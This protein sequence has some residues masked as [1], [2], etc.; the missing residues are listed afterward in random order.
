MHPHDH[1]PP[2]KVILLGNS[3]V[4]KTSLYNRWINNVFDPAPPPTIGASNFSK[5]VDLD[6]KTIRISLWDTAGQDQFRS[7]TPLYI[8]GAK[9]A[10][11]VAE[12]NVE[13]FASLEEWLRMVRDTLTEPIGIVLAVNKSE[14]RE[15]WG[16][17]ELAPL[18][19]KQRDVFVGVFAVSAKMGTNV[20]LL[21]QEAARVADREEDI[22]PS[23]NV[24]INNQNGKGNECC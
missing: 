6:T 4:G 23:D 12:P 24:A 8:R 2:K 9:C 21:F 15:P 10:V 13:S 22:G 1:V 17:Q 19:E 11:I 14:I 5:S 20:D 7:I 16:D 3:G 18:M